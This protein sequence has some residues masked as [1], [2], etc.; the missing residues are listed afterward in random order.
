MTARAAR[1]SPAARRRNAVGWS[2]TLPSIIVMA[3]LTVAPLA[4]V[5]IGGISTQGWDKLQLLAA[6]PAFGD[7]LTNTFI[8]V[9]AGTA[10]SLAFG[11]AGALALQHRLVKAKGVWRA[12]LLI[13]WITPT[14]V[15]ATAWKWFYSRDYGV[16]NSL[17]MQAGIIDEP[18]GWLTDTRIALLAVVL[19]HVWATFSF[20][21][22]MISAA[23]QTI[24]QELYEAARVD[25]AGPVRTFRSI[26]LPS[27]ADIVFIV[28]LIVTV[29]TLNSFLPVWVMTGGG[30]A[31]ATN[32][33][34]VQL[35]QYFLQG[36]EGAIHVLATIQL[37]IT[38]AIAAFYVQRTRRDPQS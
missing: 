36:D 14:V 34:P 2:L 9:V 28:T 31:G 19:V 35:Y 3:A 5:L 22:L 11:T 38:M 10:G 8:W 25:G 27:I 37:L 21:M 33:L 13:P 26:V 7:L 32:I 15:A 12:I 17:L 30:P 4:T 6:N 23:L 16:L 1:S 29:W 20:V 24:P 18:V